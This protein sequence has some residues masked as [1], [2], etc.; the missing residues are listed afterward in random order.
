MAGRLASLLLTVCVSAQEPPFA[1][2]DA[3]VAPVES[4]Q[5][6]PGLRLD[7]AGGDVLVV[8][9][10]E[11]LTVARTAPTGRV[12]A[13]TRDVNGTVFAGADTG[14][15][16]LDDGHLV[17]DPAD[18]RDGVPPGA[19]RGVFA[20]GK[21]RL[22]MCT[23]TAFAAMDVGFCYGRT[24]GAGDGL[25]A[26]P[27]R[28]VCD[29]GSG[30][31][32]LATAAGVFA[33]TP[34]RGEGPRARGGVVREQLKASTGA[35]AALRLDVDALGGATLRQRRRHHHLLEPVD[36]DELHGLRAG[37]HVV[38]VYAVDRDLRRE[39]VAEYTVQ[40]PLPQI[41][42]LR[43]L[44]A[45]AAVAG[46]L[47]F[48]LAFCTADPRASLSRRVANAAGRAALLGVVALQLLAACL[49]YGRSW[50]FVGFSMYTE[51]YRENAV[52]YQPRIVALRA[53][54]SHRVMQPHEAGVFQDGYWQML[55]EVVHGGDHARREFL[56]LL[57]CCRLPGE[58]P[59]AGYLLGDGRIRLTADGPFDVA[60]TIFV[61]WAR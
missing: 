3:V 55:A 21:G 19:V 57:D 39:L 2:V 8:R 25:P 32:L 50:P 47:L 27:F 41:L 60:P 26:P 5:L 17:L 46:L 28:G 4:I 22:W 23:D 59:Y 61:R 6:G 42:D 14:L 53:D 9:G 38:E 58:A 44:P 13:L 10:A 11:R 18:V 40:V 7:L 51:T 49:G 24:F 12:N 52:L 16:V 45:F 1:S 48:A 37:T 20:D 54:G 36:G 15:F 35:A 34:D 30:R 56:G 31:V 29:G 33:Y 43:V